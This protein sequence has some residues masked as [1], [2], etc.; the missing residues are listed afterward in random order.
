M[1]TQFCSLKAALLCYLTILNALRLRLSSWTLVSGLLATS[2]PLVAIGQTDVSVQESNTVSQSSSSPPI[3]TGK[4][5][6]DVFRELLAQSP[7]ERAEFLA[8]RTPESRKLILAKLR[9]YESLSPEERALRLEVTELRWF[10]LPLMKMPASNRVEQL[11]SVPAGV[12]KLVED[13][14]NLWDRL[15]TEAKKE[16]LS[17]EDILR[18]YFECA[19]RNGDEMVPPGPAPTAYPHSSPLSEEQ[20]QA[21][22]NNL[23]QFFLLTPQEKSKVL[24]TLSEPERQQIAKTLQAFGNLTPAQR[25]EC[26]RSFDKF[27]CLAL[28]EREQFLKSAEL[29]KSLSPGERQ[30]WKDLVYKLSRLPPIPPG[31]GFPPLPRPLLPSAVSLPAKQGPAGPVATNDHN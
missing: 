7:G 31:L 15:P 20:R 9:E 19:V 6:V 11:P 5:P 10:L 13:R 17:N 27:A 8:K 16:V 24:H 22:T 25:S 2:I 4:S 1:F 21:I 30:S 28:K 12:R 14:L 18:Y 3:P 29:W 26:L 23:A